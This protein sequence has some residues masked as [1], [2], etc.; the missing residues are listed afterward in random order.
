MFFLPL[1]FGVSGEQPQEVQD[2]LSGLV[3]NEVTGR[4]L[5][6]ATV[7][8]V[9][10]G[11]GAR[12][13]SC[14]SE[15]GGRFLLPVSS[16]HYLLVATHPGF[17][18]SPPREVMWDEDSQ[19]VSGVL[20]WVSPLGPHGLEIEE[21][22]LE[23]RGEAQVLGRFVDH[24]TG[25]PIPD[26]EVMLKAS[27]LTT[28]S[29]P[30]G[31]FA[32]PEVQPG[33]E[34]LEAKHLSYGRHLEGLHLEGGRSYRV[35]G[36]LSREPIELEG[37]EVAATS[38]KWFQKMDD[39]RWR[40]QQGLGGTYI[41][42]DELEAR[43]H[44]S[45]ADAIQGT[46]RLT[47]LRYGFYPIIINRSCTTLAGSKEPVI[48]LDGVKVH[49]PG[50]G[51]PMYVLREVAPM[52]IEA[53]EIYTGASAVPGEYGGSDAQCGVILIWTKRAPAVQ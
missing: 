1:G 9:D 24:E 19:S 5:V 42:A 4:P 3:F 12:V 34:I 30:N 18:S 51:N 37:I 14:V 35:E 25:H 53:I 47:V 21:H 20:L 7:E 26:V 23:D 38:R 29:D 2:T 16:G 39:L 46:P 43:G 15:A 27:G 11:I 50:S 36:K 17:A 6:G 52:D 22:A 8:L 49:R 28:L 41:L 13:G 10:Y 48:Y 40:M 44:P 33:E 31:M 32:F 45:V